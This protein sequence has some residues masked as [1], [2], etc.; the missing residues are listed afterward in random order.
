MRT[1]SSHA[2][3]ELKHQVPTLRRAV[4]KL[5]EGFSG[6]GNAVFSYE[7]AP[8]GHRCRPGC[9]GSCRTAC[10]SKPRVRRGSPIAPNSQTMGGIVERFIDHDVKRS[11]S[12]Q[13]RIDPLG[14]GGVISTHDQ[15]LGGPS[16]QMFLGCTFPA[17]EAYRLDI[18]HA[19]DQVAEVLRQRGVIGRFAVDFLSVKR[20]SSGS[21]MP[22]RSTC[23]KV[24]RR[25]RL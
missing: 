7:E 6:D 5:N 14:Q 22:L 15:V 1:T 20:V 11:P 21:I 4:V 10:S 12:A 13:C 3:A 25:I 19:G 23:A 2:L 18:Q 9:A 24:E 8:T 17:N 16:G